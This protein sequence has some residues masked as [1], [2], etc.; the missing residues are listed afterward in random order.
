MKRNTAVAT[1]ATAVLG[2]SLLAGCTPGGGGDAAGDAA[3]TTVRVGFDTP[4]SLNP[5]LALSLPDYQS[6]RL[7]FDTLVRRDAD[8]VVPGLASSWQGDQSKLEFTIREGATC[9]D[10]TPI[11]PKVVADSLQAYVEN[12]TPVSVLNTF[13]GLAPG[14]AADDAA[15][16]VTV[17]PEAPWGDMLFGLTVANTGIICP[18]G[19]ADL[20]GLNAGRVEGAESGPYVLEK[21]EPGVRYTYQLRD[22]YDAWPEWESDI[23]GDAPETIEYTVVKDP[24]ASANQVLSGQLDLAR[25][26][27][28]SRSRFESDEQIELVS[29]PFGNFYVLFNERPGSVFADPA[30]REAV[31]QV[32]DR[33]AFD[34]TTTDGTGEITDTFGSTATACATVDPR[35]KLTELDP[36]AAAQTLAGAKIRILGAQVVGAAG[37]GNVYLEEVLREAGADVTLDNLDIG[38]WAGRTFGQPETWDLTIYPDLNFTGTL[39]TGIANFTGPDQLEG[40]SNLGGTQSPEAEALVAQTRELL[41]PEQK[42]SIDA[43]TVAALVEGHHTI[44]LVV[45]S[46]IYAQRPGYSV[47]ML[48]GSLDDHIFR[49]SR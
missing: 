33:D 1:A 30:M 14:I 35:P 16:T 13:G 39:T 20:E 6:N 36:E 44:P 34:T 46:F 11:T 32:L 26:M 4:Q 19:L 47:T 42:C 49:I 25:I 9:S 21:S 15:G 23:P 7:S 40:G 48:G 5:H 8:G 27:P 24:S 38:S 43:Q 3:S 28:D 29:N 10:G 31:A 41:T 17:T 2:V 18:A 12:A 37:A 45:E 22:D